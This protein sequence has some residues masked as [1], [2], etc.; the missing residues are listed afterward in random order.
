MK[1][2][3]CGAEQTLLD[4][5]TSPPTCTFCGAPIVS[6]SYA[7]PPHQAARRSCRSRSIARA[8]RT[9]SAAGCAGCWLAPGDLKRYAQSDAGLAGVYLPYWTYDCHTASDYA[10]ER[11]EDYY[12]TRRTATDSQGERHR[13]RRRKQTRWSPASGHVEHFHDDVLVHGLA[14]AARAR[15]T[16]RATRVEH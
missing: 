14:H 9:S 4:A 2:A 16:A 10:G 1:C 3:K 12:V 15:C 11:G 13:T 5:A 7:E 8:R 6:K